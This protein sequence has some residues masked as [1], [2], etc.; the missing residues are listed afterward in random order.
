MGWETW[1]I[2]RI[3]PFWPVTGEIRGFGNAALHWQTEVKMQFAM[4]GQEKATKGKWELF[5]DSETYH[6]LE[7]DLIAINTQPPLYCWSSAY[8]KE[9]F[10]DKAA[11]KKNETVEIITRTLIPENQGLYKDNEWNSRPSEFWSKL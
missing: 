10:L 6:I 2:G 5:Q 9:K 8:L 3:Q 1:V 4:I 7:N 11:K